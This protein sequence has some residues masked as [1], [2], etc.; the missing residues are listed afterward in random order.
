MSISRTQFVLLFVL[1]AF[2]FIFATGSLLDQQPELF[3]GSDTQAP[4]QSVISTI[5]SPIKIVLIG[6]LL[7][8]INFLNQDP[9]APPPFYLIGFAIYWTVFALGLHFAIGKIKNRLRLK[10]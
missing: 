7:P 2:F 3:L 10:A 5:L 8:F 4:W 6:P 1:F 9:D